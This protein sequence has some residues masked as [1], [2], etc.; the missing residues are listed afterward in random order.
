MKELTTVLDGEIED[1]VC[2]V[3]PISQNIAYVHLVNFS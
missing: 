2:G 1:I 3:V